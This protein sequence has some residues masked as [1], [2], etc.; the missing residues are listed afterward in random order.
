MGSF[1][2]IPNLSPGRLGWVRP[3]G[4]GGSIGN[5]GGCG[6]GNFGGPLG[7]IIPILS[8]FISSY[9][10]KLLCKFGASANS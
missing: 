7:G 6:G 3:G 4:T 8:P 9:A 10:D 2:I 1:G 5:L